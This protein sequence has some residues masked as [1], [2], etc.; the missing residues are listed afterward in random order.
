MY[1]SYLC[2]NHYVSLII[3][4]QPLI[5]VCS[6]GVAIV[7][8]ILGSTYSDLGELSKARTLLERSV[9]M[10]K[11]TNGPQH[12]GTSI[13]QTLLGR[14]TRLAGDLPKARDILETALHTKELVYGE[15]HPGNYHLN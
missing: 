6:V 13:A 5:I 2:I 10:N 15:D 11:A 1:M 3:V 12:V 7:L 8:G 9:E 4:T 14:V